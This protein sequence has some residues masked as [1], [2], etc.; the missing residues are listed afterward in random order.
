MAE[1]ERHE[2]AIK[3]YEQALAICKRLGLLRLQGSFSFKLGL[4]LAALKRPEATIAA[5]EEARDC[6]QQTSA[7]QQL[8]RVEQLFVHIREARK[9]A[10]AE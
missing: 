1:Q 6:F 5:F 8:A 10:S 4:S 7:A 9:E 2:Q 3:H